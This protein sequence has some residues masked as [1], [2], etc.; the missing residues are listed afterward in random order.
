MDSSQTGSIE[1]GA[2]GH[3]H[4]H[5]TALHSQKQG[6]QPLEPQIASSMALALSTTFRCLERQN[7]ETASSKFLSEN[8]RLA[9]PSHT[10]FCQQL[11]AVLL[12]A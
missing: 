3:T 10:K 4:H 2:Q 1:E 9:S 6:H 8:V 7:M 5:Q 11:L 12:Q